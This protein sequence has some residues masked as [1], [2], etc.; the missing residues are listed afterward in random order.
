VGDD[1]IDPSREIAE[2][3][4]SLEARLGNFEKKS[5]FISRWDA[6]QVRR[7]VSTTGPSDRG[8]VARARTHWEA[9]R[10]VDL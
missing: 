6:R 7:A 4:Q 10:R 5:R 8:R 1:S 3:R 9:R 2:M